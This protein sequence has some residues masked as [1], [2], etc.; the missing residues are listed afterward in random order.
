LQK[1]LKLI[2]PSLTL[3]IRCQSSL[4]STVPV[5]SQSV[6]STPNSHPHIVTYPLALLHP[7]I[8]TC[9]SSFA[10]ISLQC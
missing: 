6:N 10:H 8:S 4:Q 2:S 7:S 3:S 9:T 5:H 1:S